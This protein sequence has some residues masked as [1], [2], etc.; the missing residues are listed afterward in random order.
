MTESTKYIKM[1]DG[2]KLLS[3]LSIRIIGSSVNSIHMCTKTK[4]KKTNEISALHVDESDVWLKYRGGGSS[5]LE[6][7]VTRA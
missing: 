4:Q 1:N 2:L 7:H 3:A 6:N 5:L